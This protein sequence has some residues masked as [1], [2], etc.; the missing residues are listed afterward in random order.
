MFTHRYRYWFAL[1][2]SLY[3]YINT[4]FCKVYYYFNIRIEWYAALTTIVL[5]TF[6]ILETNRYLE[7]A[8]RKKIPAEKN[9]IRFPVV[10]FIAG[11]IVS[12]IITVIIVLFMGMVLHSF[13]LKE[14]ITPLKLN[15]TYGALANLL[16]HLIN[17]IIFYFKEILS[18]LKS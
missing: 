5:I 10:F 17:T 16:Y 13:S 3:T 2:L 11:T 12:S 6:V 9:N 15:L 18:W 8:V 14:N 7:I 4:E 1:L